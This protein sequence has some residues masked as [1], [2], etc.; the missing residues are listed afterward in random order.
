[1]S[2][3]AQRELSVIAVSIVA[4][5]LLAWSGIVPQFLE[6]TKSMGL[7]AAFL[8][9]FFFVS[10]FTAA[11]AGVVFIELIAGGAWFWPTVLIA[12]LGA[13]CG[14]L[15]IMFFIR[16]E[17]DAGISRF[18]GERAGARLKAIFRYKLFRLFSVL[19]G[20][21]VVAS[22]LPDEVGLALMGF[23]KIKKRF[24]IPLSFILNGAGLLLIA[25][26]ARAIN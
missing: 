3:E 23:S 6:L 9:G 14:D 21:L 17:L 24:L 5:I 15:L 16:R 19:L 1:M 2:R 22:P 8:A 4:A 18:I 13:M 7:V 25:L 11:P 10:V 26:A 20:A 12:S